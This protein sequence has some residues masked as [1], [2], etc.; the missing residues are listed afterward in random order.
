VPDGT[1]A[2][3][4]SYIACWKFGSNFSP[5][6]SNFRTPFFSSVLSSERSVSS[7]PSIKAFKPGSAVSR[8]SAGTA[9]SARCRLSAIS[10]MSRAKPVMPYV[11]A[12]ATSRLVRLR[13]F[14]ISASVRNILS[15][16]SAASLASASTD[17]TS[18]SSGM[19]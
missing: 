14:S 18:G 13:R 5:V 12:S 19:M 15:R 9:S 16:D 6:G 8:N 3:G 4:T 10:R 7:T 17:P 11:R 1:L 2:S